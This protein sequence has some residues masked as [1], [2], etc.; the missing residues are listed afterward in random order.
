MKVFVSNIG[1]THAE[2]R[3]LTNF[4]T[5]GNLKLRMAIFVKNS[6][7]PG[8]EPWSQTNYDGPHDLR[9][10]IYGLKKG[11]KY[12]IV[13]T[14]PNLPHLAAVESK[15]TTGGTFFEGHEGW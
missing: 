9:S 14:V 2:F 3:V 5:A 11:K 7:A 8:I 4:S 1:K 10:E 15:F 13:F 6:K 12:R